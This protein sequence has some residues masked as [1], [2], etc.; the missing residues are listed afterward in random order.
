MGFRCPPTPSSEQPEVC[1]SFTLGLL[2]PPCLPSTHS[3]RATLDNSW[4]QGDLS[5]ISVHTVLEPQAGHL[6]SLCPRRG[7]EPRGVIPALKA[8]K[9]GCS[10]G[11][12]SS[13]WRV[14]PFQSRMT[15]RQPEGAQDPS[16]TQQLP[17]A[18]L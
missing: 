12:P 8:G 7:L 10:D 1:F 2:A 17:H 5:L 18:T 15:P 3:W 4:G 9:Q 16:I 13:G 14:G 6:T 11:G